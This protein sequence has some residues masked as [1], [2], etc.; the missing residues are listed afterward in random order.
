VRFAVGGENKP[1]AKITQD[2]IE[3]SEGSKR[4]MLIKEIDKIAGTIIVF[5]RTKVRADIV[6]RILDE[7]GHEAAAL[8]GD[9]TQG[10]RRRVT[11]RFRD[12]KIRIL[13][14]TDIAARGLDIPHVRHV[15]NFD[16]PMVPEDYVHRI[17]RTGRNGAEGHSIAFITPQEQKHWIRIRRTMGEQVGGGSRDGAGA[18]G[19]RRDGHRFND[20]K[21]RGPQQPRV[22]G[23]FGKR[24]AQKQE[25]Q[26]TKHVEARSGSAHPPR[27][28][29][30]HKAGGAPKKFGRAT[31]RPGRGARPDG[32]F[33]KSGGKK[34]SFGGQRKSFR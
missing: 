27:R 10:Q 11:E 1:I 32:G 8:H 15:I 6:A 22:P 17:G 13:V 16:L 30:P 9:L 24:R 2:V 18:G 23:A 26:Q 7:I 12:E 29:T 25:E 3:M 5:T 4:E 14:A 34:K 19:P 21:H 20:R 28:G 31:E 33:K